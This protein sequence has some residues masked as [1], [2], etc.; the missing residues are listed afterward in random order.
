MRTLLHYTRRAATVAGRQRLSRSTATATRRR[1]AAAPV[2]APVAAA[3]TGDQGRLKANWGALTIP[4]RVD[5]LAAN[6]TAIKGQKFT[7]DLLATCG[8]AVIDRL[9]GLSHAIG[10]QGIT[11][12]E[13]TSFELKA[14]PTAA[15]VKPSTPTDATGAAL[16]AAAAGVRNASTPTASTTKQEPQKTDRKTHL[17]VFRD[18]RAAGDFAKAGAYW[19][20]HAAHI[21]DFVK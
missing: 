9:I 3:P 6:L 19:R 17:E 13:A 2:A 16:E 21:G 7:D 14:R 8:G 15:A 5:R 11:F 1:A 4:D 10:K 12:V 18:L 20:E